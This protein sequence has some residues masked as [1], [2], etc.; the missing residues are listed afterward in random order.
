M[1]IGHHP[2]FRE[3]PKLTDTPAPRREAL[4]L[5]KLEI[6][7]ITGFSWDEAAQKSPAD[8]R[9][10]CIKRDVL[11]E[12]VEFINS[13]D[14]Q[15]LLTEPMYGPTIAM[16][17]S[18]IFRSLHTATSGAGGTGAD[19]GPAGTPG[20]GGEDS[21]VL[22]VRRTFVGR[23]SWGARGLRRGCATW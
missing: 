9:A 17:S 4:Y 15:R 14:G 5:Q 1:S 21:D 6:A 7:S 16:I 13:S 20:E 10:K 22:L 8:E 18:N 11:L 19:E 3:L 23:F 12:L 2:A